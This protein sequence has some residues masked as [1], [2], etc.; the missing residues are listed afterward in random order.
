M[1]RPAWPP[2]CSK[3]RFS[4]RSSR[5]QLWSLMGRA[6][7]GGVPKPSSTAPKGANAEALSGWGRSRVGVRQLMPP[8]QA[9]GVPAVVGPGRARG[10]GR[11][12]LPDQLVEL[13]PD[14]LFDLV[15][16]RA[17]QKAQ[18]GPLLE[19]L[20]V[21][22]QRAL[23]A[24]PAEVQHVLGFAFFVAAAHVQLAFG[25][26]GPACGHLAGAAQAQFM[27]AVD[28]DVGQVQSPAGGGDG[29]ADDTG[30]GGCRRRRRSASGSRAN[31]RTAS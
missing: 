14:L 19:A 18:R 15:L 12:L 2:A 24:G 22:V 21:H 23:R 31:C 10:S 9:W 13:A 4:G 29:P 7:A 26:F 5:Q 6:C 30:A 8:R 3:C 1:A 27:F 17:Q 25:L 11:A 16:E 28:V 20:G